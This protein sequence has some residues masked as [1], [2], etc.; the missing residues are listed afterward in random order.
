VDVANMGDRMDAHRKAF[1]GKPEGKRPL[2]RLKRNWK[3]N[4]KI[5]HQ[6]TACGWRWTCTGLIWFWIGTSGG[7]L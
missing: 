3:D 6:E 1:V 5:S 7:L 2:G 4:I